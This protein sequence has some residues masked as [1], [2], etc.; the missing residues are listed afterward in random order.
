MSNTC[1]ILACLTHVGVGA[2]CVLLAGFLA[3]GIGDVS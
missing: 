2:E 3:A 1:K